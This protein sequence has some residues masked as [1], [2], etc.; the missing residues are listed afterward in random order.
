MRKHRHVFLC[1]SSFIL[2]LLIF[3]GF[4]IVFKLLWDSI[5]S[6]KKATTTLDDYVV[7]AGEQFANFPPKSCVFEDG[8]CK[9]ITVEHESFMGKGLYAKKDGF[10]LDGRAFRIYSGTFHYFRTH[11]LQWGDRLLKM[12]AAGLNTVETYIPWNYHERSPKVYSFIG[13]GDIISFIKQVKSL[14]LLIIIRPGPYICSEWDFGGLPSW[15][16]HDPTMRVRTSGYQ[17]YLNH[18]EEYF[19]QLLPKLNGY[20]YKKGG[21]IIAYQVENEFGAFGNDPT[22][23]KF[24]V[25]MF[26]KWNI[27]E[28]LLT[29]DSSYDLK[30]GNLPG[31]LA[32]VNFQQKPNEHFKRLLEFQPD[33]PLFVV[34]YWAGW[35]DHWSENHHITTVTSFEESVRDILKANASINFYIFVGGTNFE[36]WNGANNNTGSYQP[37][38]TSYDYDAPITEAGD[39]TTKFHIVKKLAQEFNIASFDLPNIP[40]N[41]LKEKY[42]SVI[43]TGCLDLADLIALIDES[44]I[45]K[46]KEPVPMEAL[47]VNNNGGQSFGWLLYKTTFHMGQIL[48]IK[49]SVY[50][51]AQIFVNGLEVGLID[52]TKDN[53]ILSIK[54]KGVRKGENFLEI[55]V[56]NTGRVNY[57][58]S[59][60]AHILSQQRKGIVGSVYIDDKLISDWTHIPLEFSEKFKLMLRELKAIFLETNIRAA[61]S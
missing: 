6:I 29:S 25:K 17:Q 1:S 26:E 50:D 48:H 4:F 32:T 57:M 56:E 51:R 28:L 41:S 12:K 38:I 22:Y 34:E 58:R 40:A 61:R 39:I 59:E 43:V 16:L 49:G 60:R 37:T 44:E 30:N 2:R 54:L 8:K 33:K 27:N 42:G 52:W 24:L 46:L 13:M 35:F 19:D 55:L 7:E 15:L 18:V 23:L 3:F 20:S 31:L 21:P 47:N 10:Y 14:G 36:F 53:N 45:L 5:I 11:Q 9:T